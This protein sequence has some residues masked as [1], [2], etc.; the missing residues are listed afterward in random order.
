MTRLYTLLAG[1]CAL[2]G[3]TSHA[4]ANAQTIQDASSIEATP[5]VATAQRASSETLPVVIVAVRVRGA[6]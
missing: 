1:A 5:A 2:A 6:L 4:S 3:L